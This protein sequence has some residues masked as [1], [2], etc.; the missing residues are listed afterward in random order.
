M[1]DDCLYIIKECR[2]GWEGMPELSFFLSLSLGEKFS[3]LGRKGPPLLALKGKGTPNLL[4]SQKSVQKIRIFTLRRN[5]STP[6]GHGRK[7]TKPRK[8][9]AVLP[10]MFPPGHCVCPHLDALKATFQPKREENV[11]D[12]VCSIGE[13]QQL[14]VEQRCQCRSDATGRSKVMG[15]LSFPIS[16]S[17]YTSVSPSLASYC[18]RGSKTIGAPYPLKGIGAP[19]YSRIFAFYSRFTT[20]YSRNSIVYSRS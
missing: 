1:C 14:F 9:I 8:T 16:Y 17:S 15:L 11:C 7:N 20:I 2:Y 13:S 5:L 12:M 6:L 4:Y 10:V 18:C 19:I 3:F